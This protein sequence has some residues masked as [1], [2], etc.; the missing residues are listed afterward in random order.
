ML[1]EDI[2][3]RA[4]THRPS[5]SYTAST[6]PPRGGQV[7][8]PPVSDRHL[9]HDRRSPSNAVPVVHCVATLRRQTDVSE[10]PTRNRGRFILRSR[11][12]HDDLQKALPARAVIAPR[13]HLGYVVRGAP[14]ALAIGALVPANRAPLPERVPRLVFAYD[15][16]AVLSIAAR[17]PSASVNHTARSI[18]RADEWTLTLARCTRHCPAGLSSLTAS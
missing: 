1:S 9:I 13:P 10:A 3:Y 6:H 16:R 11:R 4:W 7:E 2:G 14:I 15:R 18:L 8:P 17:A 5:S 12:A